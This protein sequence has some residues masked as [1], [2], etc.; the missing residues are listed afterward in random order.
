MLE[1]VQII[2]HINV[3]H[4][5]IE[6]MPRSLIWEWTY[7]TINKHKEV[8]IYE[9]YVQCVYTSCWCDVT[10]C[11]LHWVNWPSAAGFR[12]DCNPDFVI[13][14]ALVWCNKNILDKIRVIEK[15][16]G[17]WFVA[18]KNTKTWLSQITL[19]AQAKPQKL[20]LFSFLNFIFQLSHLELAAESELGGVSFGRSLHLP[21][22]VRNLFF[23]VK[24]KSSKSTCDCWLLPFA[25]YI[26]S[27]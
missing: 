24:P 17:S 5:G 14:R 27:I 3:Y 12:R 7:Y 13:E 18:Q 23:L 20:H 21:V 19:K 25:C 10:V 26:Y 16:W 2:S 22:A 4:I 6:H 9:A 15:N 11:Y 8:W 1:D